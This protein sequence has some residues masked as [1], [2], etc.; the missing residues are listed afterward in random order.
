MA[1]NTVKKSVFITFFSRHIMKQIGMKVEVV[2]WGINNIEKIKILDKRIVI[3]EYYPIF[4]RIKIEDNWDKR[5][6][7][8]KEIFDK[9]KPVSMVHLK[10]SL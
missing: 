10:F 6:I 9:Q 2:K 8:I 1:F 4:S 5:L 7:K 3:L